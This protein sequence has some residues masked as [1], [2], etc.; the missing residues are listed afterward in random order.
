MAIPPKKSWRTTA[1]TQFEPQKQSATGSRGVVSTNNPLASAAGLE[2]LALGGNAF[3]AAIAAL[4]TL[5]VVE[6]MMVGIL[7]AGWMTLRKADGELIA[8]DNYSTAPAAASADLYTPI[9]DSWPDYMETVGDQN[10]LGLSLI[11]I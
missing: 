9:S 10:K 3:D 8:I 4:F 1:G 5:S 6:P 2:M 7:G 11:H